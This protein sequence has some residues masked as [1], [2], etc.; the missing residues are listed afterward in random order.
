MTALILDTR[1]VEAYEVG[2]ELW[3]QG[4]TTWPNSHGRVM[5]IHR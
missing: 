1:L 2:V 3:W 5:G 4:P